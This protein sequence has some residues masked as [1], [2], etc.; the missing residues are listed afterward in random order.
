MEDLK[1]PST[2]EAE[3]RREFQRREQALSTLMQ[4]TEKQVARLT[5][6][7]EQVQE[8][9][10][11]G[12]EPDVPRNESSIPTSSVCFTV[13]GMSLTCDRDTVD[14]SD[15]EDVAPE[16]D[17][18]P[19]PPWFGMLDD[20]RRRPRHPTPSP[21]RGSSNTRTGRQYA[22]SAGPGPAFD[23][24]KDV[25]DILRTIDVI[26]K[27]ERG[28]KRSATGYLAADCRSAN[29]DM[30][31]REACQRASKEAQTEIGRR[32]QKADGEDITESACS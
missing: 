10:E 18:P 20:I 26:D 14:T 16:E 12:P 25:D 24:R 17:S 32:R 8:R 7:I 6:A 13:P 5:R 22:H 15:D 4:N 1:R 23:C 30:H 21:I 19:Q 3:I 9:H 31:F 28:A 27:A 29:T 11:E 2:F